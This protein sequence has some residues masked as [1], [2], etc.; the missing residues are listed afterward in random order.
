MLKEAIADYEAQ[1]INEAQYLNKVKDIM[2][3]VLSHTDS[4]IPE[5]LTK[6]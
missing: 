2:N 3:A 5:S 6:H 1:R 4:D